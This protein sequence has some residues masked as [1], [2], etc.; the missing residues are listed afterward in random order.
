MDPLSIALASISLVHTCTKLAGSISVFINKYQAVDATI[1]TLVLDIKSLSQV[2]T[3]IGASF[4]DPLLATAALASQT[5]HEAQHWKNVRR[6]LDDCRDTL[7]KLEKILENIQ[8]AESGLLRRPRKM[9]K[10]GSQAEEI[11]LLQHEVTC[12]TRAMQLSLQLI[13]M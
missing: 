9:L 1:S 13:T 6:S 3:S 11:T 4:E 5:G 2:L 10:L 12:Y 7:D 8:K